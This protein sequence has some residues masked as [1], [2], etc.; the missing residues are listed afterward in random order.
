MEDYDEL[1]AGPDEEGKLCAMHNTWRQLPSDLLRF[2]DK[3][4]HL[5]MSYNQITGVS[6]MIGSFI[7]LEV[8]A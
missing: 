4:M 2:S 6:S 3:L 8:C 5:N 1:S 7:L